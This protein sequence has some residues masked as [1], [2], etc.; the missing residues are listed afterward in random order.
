[1]KTQNAEKETSAAL[2][3]LLRT[4]CLLDGGMGSQLFERLR[5]REG[6][7][8][9][10][11]N[12]TDPFTVRQIHAD[13]FSAGSRIVCANTFG[14]NPVKR[15]DWL[16]CLTEGLR[17][18]RQAADESEKATGQ[19]RFVALDIGPT[20]KVIG[21]NLTFDEAYAAYAQ[22]VRAGQSAD[23]FLVET[24]SDLAELRACI[25]AVREN[26][27]KPLLCSMTFENSGRTVF[28]VGIESFALTASGMGADAIGINCSLGPDGLLPH[29]QKLV[30]CTD[31]PVFIKP[32][33][34]LPRL[35]GGRTVYD[36]TADDFAAAMRRILAAGVTV[37]GGCCG[38]TPAC[39]AAVHAFFERD[40]A[41]AQKVR[42]QTPNKLVGALCSAT[43]VVQGDFLVAG[44]CINPYGKPAMQQALQQG[45]Y[46]Y[47]T[48]MG[49]DQKDEGADLLDVNV[50]GADVNEDDCLALAVATV[51]AGTGMPLCIDTARPLAMERA[52]RVY[53]GKALLNSTDGTDAMLSVMLPL[54]KKYGAA[55]VGGCLDE[56]GVPDSVEGR[57]RVAQKI[58][59][60]AEQAGIPKSDIY[61]DTLVLVQGLNED[62]ARITLQTLAEVRKLGVKTILGLSGASYGMPCREEINATFLQLAKREGLNIALLNPAHLSV[63]PTPQAED[64]LLGK[65]EA[66]ADFIAY[67]REK[68]Q[69]S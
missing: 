14:A 27:D 11:C 10:T 23:C 31:L 60:A 13:Y 49:L 34:G 17:L 56:Q 1:M 8:S 15:G 57:V 55:V 66:T 43:R 50:G 29:A 12:I 16:L 21:D 40:R 54:A 20:G 30:Q 58:I 18:V 59:A 63:S 47:L 26:S 69:R 4:G 41:A 22:V 53:N 67:A 48:D 3:D 25:L 9:E 19:K 65:E 33:A 37:L 28:G 64:F 51:A 36:L 44:E 52:L 35:V 7:V 62:S 39:I 32:N 46:D 61:I 45:D 2:R 38:T 68:M 5:Y 6:L 24:M 42:A